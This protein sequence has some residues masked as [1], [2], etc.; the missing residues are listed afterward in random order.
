MFNRIT[1]FL[2][3][4]KFTLRT[5]NVY[6][7]TILRYQQYEQVYLPF[8]REPLKYTIIFFLSQTTFASLTNI[9][10]CYGI[11]YSLQNFNRYPDE[12]V[13]HILSEKQTLKVSYLWSYKKCYT[14]VNS[15]MFK[16]NSEQLNSFALNP[17]LQT[18]AQF[19]ST[20]IQFIPLPFC[21]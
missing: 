14:N 13:T 17:S 5:L 9:T 8:I 2:F 1:N 20:L 10:L 18:P 21:L 16:I 6:L 15:E 3:S 4:F 11:L 12:V 19:S 7:F